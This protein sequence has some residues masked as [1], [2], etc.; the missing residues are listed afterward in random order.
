MNDTENISD[1][2]WKNRRSIAV[3]FAVV[4]LAL[5]L[6]PLYRQTIICN[7]E[8]LTR[9][10][11]GLGFDRFYEHYYQAWVSQGRLLAAPIST[12]TMY[13]GFLS[14]DSELFK[15]EQLAV[16][17]V[18]AVLFGLLVKVLMKDRYFA[19]FCAV[20]MMVLLPIN[21]EH[22]LP[23]AFVSFIGIPMAIMLL[24][25]ILYVRYIQEGG[26]IRLLVSMA[27]V[28]ISSLT[29][30]AFVTFVPLFSLYAVYENLS[31]P[32]ERIFKGAVWPIL[33]G[34]VFFGIYLLSSIFYPSSYSGNKF[35]N[36]IDLFNSISIVGT[37]FIMN[38][39]GYYYT[40]PK[41]M[42]LSDTLG[43]SSNYLFTARVL[44]L[45][46]IYVLLLLVLAKMS[47]GSSAEKKGIHVGP[48]AGGLL[49]AVL[50]F[51]PTSVSA[52]YQTAIGGN[53]FLALPASFL[54]FFG[55]VFVICYIV[56]HV[57]RNTDKVYLK[58]GIILLLVIFVAPMQVNN[59][60]YSEAQSEDFDRLV[61]I[62]DFV[63]S[64]GLELIGC[65]AYYS[66]DLYVAH[67]LLGIH[68][69]YWT[70]YS[71]EYGNGI[72]IYSED[73]QTVSDDRIYFRDD[74]TFIIWHSGALSLMSKGDIP[75]TM[76]VV[77]LGD[78]TV[79]ATVTGVSVTGGWNV[80]ACSVS[81]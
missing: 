20:S 21:F 7:D 11:A 25:A 35:A 51:V 57:I 78:T 42:W 40:D 29:Y 34:V 15:I 77:L 81:G 62:E 44:L 66:P 45:T 55:V 79:T 70:N 54:A 59:D 63:K 48:V 58:A 24:A 71:N 6:I 41:Y 3:L 68:D 61:Y 38:L 75:E 49:A 46:A 2:L 22:S 16:L 12:V 76:E 69:G 23:N 10:W 60:I 19:L 74:S 4:L 52:M 80:A 43:T 47:R 50:P 26:K 1:I 30:E 67:H 5:V 27:L 36:P 17:I 8:L 56:W 33:A 37:L 9:F 72:A 39:P 18:C 65:E 28:F 73:P 32:E 13:L 14:Q 31:D 53:G 64:D